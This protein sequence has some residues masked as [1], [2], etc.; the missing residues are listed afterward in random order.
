[1][2]Q[3]EQTFEMAHRCPGTGYGE[4]SIHGHSWTVIATAEI[5]PDSEDIIDP[6]ELYDIVKTDIADVFDRSLLVGQSDDLIDLYKQAQ[7]EG[8]QVFIVD[9]IPTAQNFA[10]YLFRELEAKLCENNAMIL[11]S[12]S[13]KEGPKIAITTTTGVIAE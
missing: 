4:D 10:Q 2:I 6:E 13:L 5:P 8:N 7:S 12:I 9:F 3:V 11:R 1:M